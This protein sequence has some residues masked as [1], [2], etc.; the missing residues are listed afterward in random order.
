MHVYSGA[1]LG[2]TP[3]TLS[4]SIILIQTSELAPLVPPAGLIII[5][6][7]TEA[8]FADLVDLADLLHCS[9]FRSRNLAIIECSTVGYFFYY[10]KGLFLVAVYTFEEQIIYYQ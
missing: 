1:E 7:I 4:S 2:H 5:A 9:A 10:I 3:P 8:H 6:R